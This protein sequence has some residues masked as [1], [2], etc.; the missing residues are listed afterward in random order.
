V[1]QSFTYFGSFKLLESGENDL[2]TGK[3]PKKIRDFC[4]FSE[5]DILNPI[6]NIL[7]VQ[8]S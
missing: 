6:P 3:N 1:L 8:E 5:S 7:F 2:N 4:R